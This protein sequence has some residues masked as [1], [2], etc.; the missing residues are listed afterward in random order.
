M[1]G[2]RTAPQTNLRM[3]PELKDLLQKKAEVNRRSLTGE[4]IARLERSLSED[5]LH[6]T[7]QA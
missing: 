5:D 2:A 1:K 7:K 4:I 3:P 6:E